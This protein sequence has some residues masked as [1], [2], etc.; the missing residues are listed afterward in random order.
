MEKETLQGNEHGKK[1]SGICD[2]ARK[3]AVGDNLKTCTRERCTM[4]YEGTSDGGTSMAL[5]DIY[6]ELY[7]VEG[8]TGGVSHQHEVWQIEAMSR[9][10][11][12]DSPVKFSDIFKTLSDSQKS[13]TVLTLGIAGVGKTVSVQK[14]ALEWAEGKINQ[15]IEFVFLMPFRDLNPIMEEQY[16][17]H[18]LLSYFY[19]QLDLRREDV[20]ALRDCNV[21][22][23]FDGL[24]ES[25]L[26]LNFGN[27]KLV[28]D[29]TEMSS[30]DLLIVN[31]IAGNMLPSA[32]I[33][34]TS[35]PAA[36][37]QVPSKHTD[38]V[39]EVRGFSDLQKEEYFRK[40]ISNQEQ[41][42]KIISH[43]K[44]SKSLHIMCHIPVF[45]WISAAV[46]QLMLDDG[47]DGEAVDREDVPTT[48][49][50]MY[51]NFMLYQ[52][53]IKLQ[54]YPGRY[55]GK[56]LK[57]ADY[58]EEIRKLA[59]LA[60][61]NLMREKFIFFEKDLEESGIDV[62]AASVY[63]GMFTEIF[64]KEKTLFRSKAYSF[65]HLSIQE[66]LAALYVFY[67]YSTTRTNP[68]LE[69]TADKLKWR[70]K[71]N[72][73][74]LHKSAINK[75]LQSESGHLDLF[76]RFLLGVSLESNQTLLVKVFPQLSL[77]EGVERTVQFIKEKIKRQILPER[78]INLLHCLNEMNDNSLV[79]EIK[80]YVQSRSDHQLTPAECSALVY[81]LLMSTD[82]LDEF[83]LRKYLKSDEGLRR[84][85]PL[86]VASRKALLNDCNLTKQSC[87]TLA[88]ALISR[89]SCLTVL[90]LSNNNLQDSGISLLVQGLKSPY[91]K[92]QLLK[93]SGCLITEKGCLSLASALSSNLSQLRKLDVSYNPTGEKGVK[94]IFNIIENPSYNL[95]EFNI[96][97]VLPPSLY[98]DR[99]DIV[100]QLTLDPNTAH[101]SLCLTDGG[102]TVTWSTK[103][104]PYKVHPDRFQ[105]WKQVMC[106]E[107]LSGQ[108]YWEAEWSG[109]VFG[110]NIGLTYR[111]ISRTGEANV[112]LAGHNDQSWSLHCSN[113]SYSALHDG[114]K[115][116]LRKT[117]EDNFESETIAVYLDWLAGTLSF[118]KILKGWFKWGEH[119][120]FGYRSEAGKPMDGWM[121]GWMR[122]SCP[123]FL[124]A[125]LLIVLS[126]C[127][128]RRRYLSQ[129]TSSQGFK[130]LFTVSLSHPAPAETP[131]VPPVGCSLN[132]SANNSSTVNAPIVN[133]NTFSGPVTFSFVT[134]SGKDESVIQ[135]FLENHKASMKKKTECIFEGKKDT[136]N[137]I[138][139]KKVYTQLF[140][141]EGELNR[142]N[143]EHEILKIVK[144]KAFHVHKSQEKAISCNEIF[145]L[146]WKDEA[147]FKTVL[148]KGIAGIGKT[149]SVQ[150]FILDWAEG[151]ANQHVDCVFLLPF[152]EINLIKD[153]EFSLHELLLEFHPELEEVKDTKTYEILKL[154]FIFDGLDESRLPLDFGSRTVRS[155]HKKAS[156][157][158]LITNLI[159]GNLLPSAVIWITS[160]PAAAH[161][162]PS[163]HVSMFTEVRGFTDKQKEEYFK[164][165]IPDEME[166]SAI[167]SHVKVSRSLYIMC[168][169]PVFCWI[170]ATV[171]Q[172]ML[173][174]NQGEVIPST[175]TEM[176]IHFL[177]IQMN[178][179]NQKYDKKV[180]R[181]LM[182]LI[183]SNKGLI[184]KL[185]KLAFEQLKK[186][187]IMFYESDL[188]DCG[189]DVTED[190]EYTGMCAEIFKQE[191]VLHEKKVYCFIHLSLQ[192]FLAALHVFYSYLNKSMD[193][194]QF[195]FDQPPA[196]LQLDLL[197]KNAVDK[198]KESEK[199]HLDL[200]LRFLLGISHEANQKLLSGLLPHTANTKKSLSKVIQHIRQIQNDGPELS[201]EKSINHFFCLLELKD[202][203]LYNQ[204]KKR[205]N[206][207]TK[208]HLSSSNCS[209]LAYILLM[210][211]EVL[212]ELNPKKYNTSNAACRR[213]IPAVRC[214]RKALF[215]DCEL[216]ESCCECVSAALQSE[217]CP[218][219]EL[220]LS[221]N[222]RLEPA[223]KLLSEGFKSSHSNLE[224]LRLNWCNLTA[225]SCK[226]ISSLLNTSSESHLRELDMSDND[227]KNEG[228]KLLSAGL[229]D[230][231][232]RLEILRLSG[233]LITEEG[234]SFL[235]SALNSNPTK[236]RE[237]DLSYNHPGESG[238]KLL[239]AGVEDPHYK[240]LLRM[241]PK[242]EHF[243]KPGIRKFGCK[244]TLDPNTAHKQ[245]LLSEDNRKVTRVT[246]KQDYPDHPERFEAFSQVLCKEGLS[247]RCYWEVEFTDAEPEIGVTYDLILRKEDDIAYYEASAQLGLNEVSWSLGFS[248]I[249]YHARHD[250]K[251]T[252]IRTTTSRF[253]RIGVF[254]DWPAGILSFYSI[255]SETQT[256]SCLH[257]FKTTFQKPLYPGFSLDFGS[258]SLCPMD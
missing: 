229:E 49:T 117:P 118:Y 196:N 88:S 72:L 143:N 18:K 122:E 128:W 77:T 12:A 130:E 32:R 152:R 62:Q 241:D 240:L 233:C 153:T 145:S 95:K 127:F 156:V 190:S 129:T 43:I 29:V 227:L 209:A 63:S 183:E 159:S 230:P 137:K 163:E 21:L 5:T 124:V 102:R 185:A 68:L 144:D 64:R 93:V 11:A 210:S 176:Y 48:L 44:K 238:E 98:L 59:E 50:G 181:D 73:F 71:N 231:K 150:K 247:D 24:D 228:I 157:D 249:G 35:R 253:G 66:F 131:V 179:K 99:F 149:V 142:V 220:D 121:D 111:G 162:I 136:K 4:I 17:L 86:V 199:G 120:K 165:R 67:M 203:S 92:L 112:S 166:A 252:D 2:E 171:L 215:A 113:Y 14:F 60:Y 27:N 47:Q 89:M 219:T 217:N 22:I 110:V 221:D 251:Y 195:F 198:A 57:F 79:E 222:Y 26:V 82:D 174:R 200:F 186:E 20:E 191:S 232:C 45:C 34:I 239:S 58:S 70:V 107:A 193:D 172:D 242:G 197:L 38:L 192:E 23:V 213:L 167:I 74:E 109:S 65:V 116:D 76:L 51:T 173:A 255:S 106:R 218:L 28:C 234:C 188:R 205:L 187:N 78:S 202:N 158:L 108:H 105:T 148:T 8:H 101:R 46:L 6:T 170:T 164:K 214:C 53:D 1:P 41:A 91:C 69:S 154:A 178:M 31:L 83:D 250:S 104:I 87:E 119:K 236:L 208:S 132:V 80:S 81:L 61:K 37:H 147:H 30:V 141:T 56:P 237:L 94:M 151:E 243:I 204:I 138:Q 133:S 100:C 135:K 201:P 244:L 140:I 84:T 161:Q 139:L 75:S 85:V 90:D 155:I 216:T 169:I 54:K 103:E 25:R 246:E 7:I 52:T 134:S 258:L 13:R 40:R 146:A 248:P 212:D 33:W 235:A 194:L 257:T 97:M 160:R 36:A 96:I 114:K 42:C 19:H 254:L 180:E 182:K 245:L 211:E 207:E 10:L 16:S 115:V 125:C 175:L 39:T 55:Q 224:I 126:I 184:L 15:D 168:H 223:A 225:K 189:I 9:V 226:F 123:E 3:K 206:E 256:L 177:L